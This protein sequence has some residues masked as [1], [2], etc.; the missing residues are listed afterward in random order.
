MWKIA[1]FLR[2][3]IYP[4][5]VVF[6]FDCSGNQPMHKDLTPKCGNL[7]PGRYGMESQPKIIIDHIKPLK[8]IKDLSMS[9]FQNFGFTGRKHITEIF[10]ATNTSKFTL[11]QAYRDM[12]HWM[13]RHVSCLS[14]RIINIY[15]LVICYVAME[16]DQ[17]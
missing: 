4:K 10:V 16:N 11:K 15:P 9:A 1:G 13:V 5:I 8:A 2:K 3:M 14:L 17:L 6:H 7:M 12:R